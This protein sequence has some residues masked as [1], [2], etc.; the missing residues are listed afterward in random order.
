MAKMLWFKININENGTLRFNLY[1]EGQ[2][3][4]D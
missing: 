2:I 1:C 4:G 3:L